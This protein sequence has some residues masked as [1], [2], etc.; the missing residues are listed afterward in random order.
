ME[1]TS[2]SST[3]GGRGVKRA[4]SP[5][6]EIVGVALGWTSQDSCLDL[7]AVGHVVMHVLYSDKFKV[8]PVHLEDV[9]TS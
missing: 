6:L 2:L 9:I 3:E 5:S 8:D 4:C 7:D 1:S